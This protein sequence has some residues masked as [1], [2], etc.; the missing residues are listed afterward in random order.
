MTLVA[1]ALAV[2]VF[3]QSKMISSQ[4]AK[5]E[6]QAAN[7]GTLKVNNATLRENTTVLRSGVEQ[8]N[9]SI[10]EAKRVADRAAANGVAALA[11][12]R[13]ANART[14][15]VIRAINA[16]PVGATPAEQCAAADAI[17]LQGATQ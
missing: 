5:I 16:I 9:A 7:I 15:D 10:A 11:E 1:I 17:L 4:T 12:A 2:A 8:C 3:T 6:G 14:G 13:K